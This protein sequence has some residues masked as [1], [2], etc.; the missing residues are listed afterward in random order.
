MVQI[1]AISSHPITFF[2]GEETSDQHITT[3]SFQVAVDSDKISLN[4]L[5]SRLP[6]L[7]HSDG[8]KEQNLNPEDNLRELHSFSYCSIKINCNNNKYYLRYIRYIQY[9]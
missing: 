6:I 3:N 5:F 1:D 8:I 2:L 7:A 9:R 4:H